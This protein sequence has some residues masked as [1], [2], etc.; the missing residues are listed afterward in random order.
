MVDCNPIIQSRHFFSQ[1]CLQDEKSI[2]RFMFYF[3]L[4]Y[5]ITPHFLLKKYTYALHFTFYFLAAPG[6]SQITVLDSTTQN[7]PAGVRSS[8]PR[9]QPKLVPH[10][11]RICRR[12]LHPKR[13]W[14]RSGPQ[15]PCS[16]CD[17]ANRNGMGAGFRRLSAGLSRSFSDH[18]SAIQPSKRQTGQM[19]Q[20]GRKDSFC[21]HQ[22]SAM[23]ATIL[24][25]YWIMKFSCPAGRAFAHRRYQHIA[26][27]VAQLMAVNM[28]NITRQLSQIPGGS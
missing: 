5:F 15:P 12:F 8:P 23:A 24:T 22:I 2:R 13:P 20:L 18:V 6:T 28:A 25:K 9:Q 1:W 16:R 26:E 10:I 17:T 11:Q 3:V 21:V 19:E 7:P 27:G 4:N 14:K